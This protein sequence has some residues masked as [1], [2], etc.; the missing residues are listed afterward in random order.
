MYEKQFKQL[1]FKTIPEPPQ[2]LTVN[3][4]EIPSVTNGEN[5]NVAFA[6]SLIELK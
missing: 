4:Y 1:D 3:D 5:K 2:H 6:S